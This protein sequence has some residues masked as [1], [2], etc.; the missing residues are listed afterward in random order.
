MPRTVLSTCSSVVNKTDKFPV[1]LDSHQLVKQTNSNEGNEHRNKMVSDLEECKVG[2]QQGLSEEV[3]FEPRPEGQ[4]GA[5]LGEIWEKNFPDRRN[6]WWQNPKVGV[7]MLCLGQHR[8]SGVNSGESRELA[9]ALPCWM[10]LSL[11]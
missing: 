9:R 11:C 6:H 1:L 2:A 3:I 5:S 8:W 10:L 4:E 7:N